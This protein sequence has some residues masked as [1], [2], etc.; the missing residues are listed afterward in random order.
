MAAEYHCK[1][2]W[3]FF[4]SFCH[5]EFDGPWFVFFVVDV[6]LEVVSPDLSGFFLGLFLWFFCFCLLVSSC[7]P[8]GGL[9]FNCHLHVSCLVPSPTIYWV[10]NDD[11]G[12]CNQIW[13]LS[14]YQGYCD[15][16]NLRRCCTVPIVLFS[17][18]WSWSILLTHPWGHLGDS[19][20]FYRC[21]ARPLVCCIC[22]GSFQFVCLS[23]LLV[24]HCYTNGTGFSS[25]QVA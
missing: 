9:S 20:A 13:L 8:R 18:Y 10:L 22:S 24:P 11:T 25:L 1:C 19:Y 6:N 21:L 23:S 15:S 17:G 5:F 4:F 14:R 16:S 2:L 3:I 12:I 7:V